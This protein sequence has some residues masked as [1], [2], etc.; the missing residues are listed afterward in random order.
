[1]NGIVCVCVA[2]YRSADRKAAAQ[3]SYRIRK[4]PLRVKVIAMS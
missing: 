3:I 2:L 1:M 4:K